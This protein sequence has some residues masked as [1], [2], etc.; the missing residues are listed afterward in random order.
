M[1]YTAPLHSG[2]APKS[3]LLFLRWA[4]LALLLTAELLGLSIRF[5]TAVLEADSTGWARFVGNAAPAFLQIALAFMAAFLLALAP[6]L[7]AIALVAQRSAKTHRWPGWLLAHLLVY[8]VFYW[9]TLTVF[10]AASSGGSLSGGLLA[11]WAGLGVANVGLWL[12]VVAPVGFWAG[13]LNDEWRALII[14]VLAGTAAW[15]GG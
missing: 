10:S 13:L 4:L 1:P 15:L 6:R 11:A 2:N 14:A 8:G 3:R 9:L 7:K 12:F 5:D